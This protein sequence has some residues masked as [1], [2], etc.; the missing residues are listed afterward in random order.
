M[1]KFGLLARLQ[2][3]PGKEKEVEAL[4]IGALPLA[5][6]EAGT[7]TWYAFRLD[8]STFGIFDTFDDETGREAHLAGQIAQALMAKADE[9]LAVPPQIDKI[10]L[11]ATK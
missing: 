10:D 7:R 8:A 6:Q 11:L 2:A 4:L 9:L 3:K 5:E 1:P